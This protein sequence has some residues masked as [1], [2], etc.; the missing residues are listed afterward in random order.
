MS[1]FALSG[2]HRPQ[3]HP[4]STLP[5]LQQAL[6]ADASLAFD[7]AEHPS[8][9]EALRRYIWQ[10][11]DNE[12]RVRMVESFL[13]RS[14]AK[15]AAGAELP[16][17]AIR[18]YDMLHRLRD[19]LVSEG[20]PDTD[21]EMTTIPGG[22]WP[23]PVAPAGAAPLASPADGP[24]TPVTPGESG[25]ELFLPDG[26]AAK[27]LARRVILGRRPRTTRGSVEQLVKIVDPSRMISL[28]HA[29]LEFDGSR[30]WI[31]DLG[32]TN[33]TCLGSDA[34]A[35]LAAPGTPYL[36]P[37]RIMLGGVTLVFRQVGR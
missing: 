5:Q 26:T 17:Q 18:F 27:L 31:T 21:A 10:R 20:H 6:T 7:V 16:V 9:D 14:D 8:A 36:L 2:S 34:S 23:R 24:A 33:G 1:Q 37:Q 11:C 12:L 29:L 13:A 30:W 15:L 35:P 3:L 4:G 25:V 22:G 28:M 32:S 19:A